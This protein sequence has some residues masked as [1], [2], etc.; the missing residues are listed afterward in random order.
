M[1][2]L[3]NCRILSEVLLVRKEK[4]LKWTLS[5][6]MDVMVWLEMAHAIQTVSNVMMS[7][8][9][10]GKDSKHV[11]LYFFVRNAHML[12]YILSS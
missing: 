11:K 4:F 6:F 12:F 1:Y 9:G 2:N 10:W 3:F 8:L 7:S 5:I